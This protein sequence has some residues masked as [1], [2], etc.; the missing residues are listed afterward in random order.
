MKNIT[1]IISLFIGIA[2]VGLSQSDSVA[3]Q[4]KVDTLVTHYHSLTWQSS[5]RKVTYYENGKEISKSKYDALN[6]E[7]IDP[8]DCTP[9]YLVA[10]QDKILI[11]EG[12]FYTDCGVG[13]YIDYYPNGNVK[14]KGEYKRNIDQNWNI[15]KVNEWCAVKNGLWEYFDESGNLI[16]SEQYENGILIE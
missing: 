8:N 6:K 1:W 13:L 4:F 10:Y 3:V 16:K 5:N 7:T 2:E 11:Y 9:C 15:D 12:D 14:S